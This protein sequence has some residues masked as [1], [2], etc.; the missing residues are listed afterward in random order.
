M[1]IIDRPTL[2][3][4][5]QPRRLTVAAGEVVLREGASCGVMYLIE[6]GEL[7]VL[8][9]AEDGQTLTLGTVRPGDMV[10]E[11][12][13]LR[14]TPHAA[15]V[16]ASTDC[17]LLEITRDLLDRFEE[18]HPST[19]LEHLLREVAHSISAHLDRTTNATIE[20]LR[21][22]LELRRVMASFLVVVVIGLAS[23]ALLVKVLS[24]R[25]FDGMVTTIVSAPILAVMAV[26][27]VGWGRRSGLPM[28]VFGLTWDDGLA[29]ARQAVLWTL[30]VL[31][32]LTLLKWSLCAWVDSF[33]NEP[34]FP[35]LH[36]PF[37]M[38]ALGP[39]LAYVVFVPVQEFVARG[40]TQG[41][42]FEF[43]SGSARRRWVLAIV[44]SNT[45]F[46][47]THLHLTLAYVTVAFVGGLLWGAL[48]ARQQSLVGPVVSHVLVGIHALDLLGFAAI[49]KRMA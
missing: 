21:R 12:S 31:A 35:G 4:A 24:D 23:Y 10:G 33:A 46:A 48:F 9:E 13:L 45:L 5:L 15:T 43:F 18:D 6:A 1:S 34:V 29:C 20:A 19:P 22:E 11:L 40:A 37:A 7:E 30:P 17:R 14:G 8:R 26:V 36:D 42:L 2:M 27:A 32:L 16:R 49:L 38:D 44:V 28:R 25:W 39:T 47:V 41:P 3:S